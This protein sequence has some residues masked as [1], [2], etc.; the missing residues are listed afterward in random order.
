MRPPPRHVASGPA[1]TARLLLPAPLALL[2]EEGAEHAGKVL[3]IPQWI[4]QLANLALFIAVLV[5]FVARPLTEAFRKRQI[6]VDKRLQEAR[7][8]RGEAARFEGQIRERM[9]RLEREI[10]EIRKQGLA[11]G[12]SARSAL[13]LRAKEEA[14]RIR[15]ESE[16]EIERRVSAAKEELRQTATNLMASAA[17]DI[18][19]S[20]INEEDRRR[21]LAESVSRL[22]EAR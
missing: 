22:K 7:E 16:D 20:E 2:A 15:K 1:G 19:S 21:L 9:E 4:W 3:G 14:E 10:E 18:V 12:E 13:D 11:D 6:E 17:R 5:Y 8:R